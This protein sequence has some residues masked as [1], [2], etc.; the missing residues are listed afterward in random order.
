[1]K[2]QKLSLTLPGDLVEEARAY[3]PDG[4][5]SA[6]VADGLYRR[7]LS[8]RL[9]R[10]LRELDEECGPLTEEE[11]ETAERVWKNAR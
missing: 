4:N 7:V 11:L 5:L 8:D 10:Y 2:A 3:A 1:M 6:Y 9:G